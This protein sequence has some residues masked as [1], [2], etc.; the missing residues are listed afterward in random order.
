MLYAGRPF[1]SRIRT[2]MRAFLIATVEFVIFVAAVKLFATEPKA[3]GWAATTAA[4]APLSDSDDDKAFYALGV[5]VSQNIASFNFTPA[6]L[7]KVKQGFTDGALGKP[8][9]VDVQTYIPRLREL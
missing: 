1:F 3:G 2:P 6:E 5:A 7:E 8:S 9:Q 4:T